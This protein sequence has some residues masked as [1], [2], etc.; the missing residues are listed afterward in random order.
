MRGC[1]RNVR[2]PVMSTRGRRV[3]LKPPSIVSSVG[4]SDFQYLPVRTNKDGK[5]RLCI[6]VEL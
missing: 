1:E 6:G 4:G 5:V 3:L 2:E